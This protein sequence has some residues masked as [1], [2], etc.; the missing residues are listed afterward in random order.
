[1]VRRSVC[2]RAFRTTLRVLGNA[3]IKYTCK[4]YLTIKICSFEEKVD[5][6]ICNKET[7]AMG[8]TQNVPI[9]NRF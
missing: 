8:C 6:I 3:R 9:F 5:H 2:S 4:V 1:M 7:F